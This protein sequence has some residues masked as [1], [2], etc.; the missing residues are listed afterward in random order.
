MVQG[1]IRVISEEHTAG[2]RAVTNVTLQPALLRLKAGWHRLASRVYAMKCFSK[3]HIDTTMIPLSELLWKRTTLVCRGGVWELVEFAED[4][5]GMSDRTA[6]F[7]EADSVEQVITVA[8]DQGD[9]PPAEM[10]FEVPDPQPSAPPAEHQ[11]NETP[12]QVPTDES[13]GQRSCLQRSVNSSCR[14]S[15]LRSMVR[16]SM[17]ARP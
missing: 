12:E 8:H 5:A 9:L 4:I 15:R 1:T 13:E 2:F 14:L 7:D 17:V 16:S 6:L 10:G 3:K 11:A